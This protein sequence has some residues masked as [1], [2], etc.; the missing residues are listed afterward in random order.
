MIKKTQNILR[1]K[2]EQTFWRIKMGLEQ[3][4]RE[5][6]EMMRIYIMSTQGKAT[7]E[8]MK[9]ANKQFQD[10][11]K[12]I[13]FGTLAIL[14]L[15]FITIPIIVKLGQKIGIDIIPKSFKE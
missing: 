9:K 3:E 4:G 14:P 15:A 5:T 11:L 13:G 8:D 10:F 1:K 2:I 7:K 6:R 12:T